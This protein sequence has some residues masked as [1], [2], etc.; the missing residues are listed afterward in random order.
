MSATNPKK[1]KLLG[2]ESVQK[3]IVASLATLSGT[4][5]I[6]YSISNE[7]DIFKSNILIIDVHD[8]L[9]V[10]NWVQLKE[11]VG[12]L[13]VIAVGEQSVAGA[14]KW[15]KR[16]QLATQ[17]LDAMDEVLTGKVQDSGSDSSV[18]AAAVQPV[19]K[20]AVADT[21]SPGNIQNPEMVNTRTSSEVD[22]GRESATTPS[23]GAMESDLADNAAASDDR[24]GRDSGS[25]ENSLDPVPV[26][27]SSD[28]SSNVIRTDVSE[29][30][31]NQSQESKSIFQSLTSI[32]RPSQFSFPVR[33]NDDTANKNNESASGNVAGAS[34]T[35]NASAQSNQVSGTASD[36]DHADTGVQ[37]ENDTE[38]Q[39][40]LNDELSQ[41]I[42]KIREKAAVDGQGINTGAVVDNEAPGVVARNDESAFDNGKVY[43]TLSPEPVPAP[44]PFGAKNESR[45]QGVGGANASISTKS[46]AGGE[47]PSQADGQPVAN[48]PK[49]IVAPEDRQHT[50]R[51]LIVDDSPYVWTQL[52]ICL[53]NCPA[54]LDFVSTAEDGLNE[55]KQRPYDLVFLDVMLPNMDGYDACK[56][57]KKDKSSNRVPVIMLTGRSA[58]ANKLKG[59]LSGC[60]YYLTKPVSEAEV[61][62]VVDRFFTRLLKKSA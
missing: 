29:P 13:P 42:S 52:R 35:G 3:A 36:S 14:T 54:D 33:S 39:R 6:Q 61:Q 30:A 37:G 12:D 48:W 26:T 47:Q 1:I 27:D 28:I 24:Q 22:P 8:E 11:I 51:F 2:F 58:P 43:P 7:D 45:H 20:P 9:V 10:E 62:A 40:R 34:E 32:A 4:R 18:S 53:E 59:V 46:P 49:K 16:S 44:N 38:N 57:I 23:A 15:V 41:A 21:A 60:N 55:I 25:V 56:I 19:P 17:L 50:S 5:S 31:A